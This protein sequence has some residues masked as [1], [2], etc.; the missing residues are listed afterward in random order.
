M[1]SCKHVESS[2]RCVRPLLLPISIGIL[3]LTA[4]DR[5]EPTN[6]PPPRASA[7]SPPNTAA[8]TVDS[9]APG[10]VTGTSAENSE[11]EAAKVGGQSGESGTIPASGKSG[12][13]T[14]PGVD[15]AV[16]SG[17]SKEAPK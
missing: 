6:Y 4:C 12:S 15:G 8:P 2:L 7:E 14:S 5:S 3:A 1:H 9:P 17:I 13:S 11:K 16:K 10:S